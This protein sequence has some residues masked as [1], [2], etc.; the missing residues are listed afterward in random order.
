MKIKKTFLKSKVAQ[1]IASLF[2]LCALLPIATLAILSFNK[3]TNHLREQS[4]TR[5]HHISKTMSMAIYERLLILESDMIRVASDFKE[6]TERSSAMSLFG[7]GAFQKDRFRGISVYSDMG[8]PVSLYGKISQKFEFTPEEKKIMH[9]GESLLKTGVHDDRTPLIILGLAV[10]PDSDDSHILLAEIDPFYLWFMG[11]ETALPADTEFIILDQ[12]NRVL[13][14]TLQPSANPSEQISSQIRGSTSGH[15]DWTHEGKEYL[16]SY[17]EIFLQPKFQTHHWTIIS[18]ESKSYIYS[19]MASFKKTFFLI[20]LLSLWIVLF[21]S[22]NQIRRSLIPLEKLKAGAQR[23]AKRDFDARITITSRDEFADLAKTFNSMAHQLGKQF[24]TL[25]TIAEIDRAIL[26]AIN[27]EDIVTTLLKRINDVFPCD[28]ASVILIDNHDPKKGMIYTGG[29]HQGKQKMK[30]RLTLSVKDISEL[31]DHKNVMIIERKDFH[32]SYLK[33]LIQNGIES[34]YVFPIF[35]QNVLAGIISFGY[36]K[37]P[38]ITKEDLDQARQL[39]DQ[40][41]VA[42][43]N[44]RLID[45]L[46]D[47]NWS[48]LKALARAIDAKSPWTA[49]H[50]ERVTKYGMEIGEELGLSAAEMDTLER[51][52]LLHDIG[53]LGIPNEILDKSEKLTKEDIQI[54][55]KHPRMGAR[56]LEPISAYTDTMHIVLQH[57][58][59]FDGTGYPEGL[60]GEEISK[61]SRIFAVADR[62]EA[63]TAERPYR[64]AIDPRQAIKFIK[65]NSGTQL[66]PAVVDAFLKVLEKKY[67]IRPSKIGGLSQENSSRSLK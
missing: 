62:Y 27:T 3:V 10:D 43:S 60:A 30:H 44:T 26:S 36:E 21:L 31:D 42:L 13:F 6:P 1:R 49:G 39:S 29:D 25:T 41:G 58:E 23:I 50:S 35:I 54:L 34:F 15:F 2:V 40:V 33:P 46:S 38:N 52:G 14:S 67:D 7:D 59:N 63:M 28:T 8:E 45:E 65:E 66:D 57:H 16:A 61:Y 11:Y 48:T 19:P 12:E 47:F 9:A 37:T 53:K 20:I 4:L 22:F 51:G 17:R 55:K 18:S 5:L 32:P 24:N 64:K 56:I